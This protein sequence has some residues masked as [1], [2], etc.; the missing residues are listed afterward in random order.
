MSVKYGLA[1]DHIYMGL[2]DAAFDLLVHWITQLRGVT[3]SLI[4]SGDE[5]WEGIYFSTRTNA[6]FEFLRKRRE[7]CIGIAFSSISPFY[8][9][10]R[11]IVDELPELPWRNGSRVTAEGKPWFDWFSVCEYL[12]VNPSTPCNVWLMHYHMNH[13]DWKSRRPKLSLD[14]ITDVAFTGSLAMR[15]EIQRVIPWTPIR[16]EEGS[17]ENIYYMPDRDES[18]LR[19]RVRFE[20]F[21][22]ASGH[23]FK[24]DY[25]EFRLAPHGEAPSPPPSPWIMEISRPG[26]IKLSVR[27]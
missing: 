26:Y 17:D 25:V 13:Y 4:R 16:I 21:Q 3:H 2:E 9:D 11:K 22:D 27:S 8:L 20:D 23:P 19:V 24:L 1:L 15:E 10:A 6:Y 18:E 14:A 12:N 7:G 5:Q